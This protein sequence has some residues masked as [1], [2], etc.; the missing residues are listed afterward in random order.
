M[1][2]EILNKKFDFKTWNCLHLAKYLYDNY[3]GVGKFP[4]VIE[5]FSRVQE[6]EG[7]NAI[8]QFLPIYCKEVHEI[9]NGC[10][11]VL[12]SHRENHLASYYDGLVWYMG[13]DSAKSDTLERMSS[14]VKSIWK[15]KGT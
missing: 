10:L 12:W 4:D 8:R 9:E 5:E 15:I 7:S 1:N 11:L 13:F 2:K 3:F 6:S 14:V